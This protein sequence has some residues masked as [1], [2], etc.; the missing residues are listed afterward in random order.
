MLTK[1]KK[2]VFID[3]DGVAADFEW[4]YTSNFGHKSGRVPDD[5]WEKIYELETFF[6]DIPVMNGFNKFILQINASGMKPTFLT[7]ATKDN[8]RNIAKQKVKWGNKHFPTTPM[9]VTPGGGSKYLYMQN[10]GDIL[11]D[12]T[13]YVCEKWERY[14]GTAIQHYGQD[15]DTTYK[16]LKELY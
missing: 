15:F 12:D 1:A 10:K 9:I 3:L 11:I 4:Q 16:K 14:G 8:F 5:M 13:T 7:A 2:N 6:E